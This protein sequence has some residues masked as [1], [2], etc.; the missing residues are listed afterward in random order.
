MHNYRQAALCLHG[1]GLDDRQWLLS[2]LPERHRAPLHALLDELE[3]LG[4]PAD[5]DPRYADKLPHRNG[6]DAL[7]AAILEIEA[8]SPEHV[9]HLLDG[10]S[11][12]VVSAML[13]ARDWS[14]KSG[15]IARFKKNH[16][17][18]TFSGG[19]ISA[20]VYAAMVMAVAARLGNGLKP[21]ARNKGW[22]GS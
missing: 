3:S 14:W 4:I 12:A 16:R 8:A 11:D 19:V 1:L 6:G 18:L 2:N 15:V 13:A 22:R 21:P 10:E 20:K 9:G 7:D 5:A 17:G